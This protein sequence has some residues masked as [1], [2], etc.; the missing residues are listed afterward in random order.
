MNRSCFI[1]FVALF[2]LPLSAQSQWELGLDLT[3]GFARGELADNIDDGIGGG[4]RFAWKPR[5]TAR[6]SAGIDLRL[7]N[8]DEN[9][10]FDP[11]EDCCRFIDE[12]ETQSNIL[13]GHLF[14]KWERPRGFLRPHFELL[15]GVK[16]FETETR[17]LGGEFEDVIEDF[18]EFDDTAFSYGCGFGVSLALKDGP[19]GGDRGVGI[20]LRFTGRLLYGT[21]ATYVVEDS[22]VFEDPQTISFEIADSETNLFTIDAGITFRF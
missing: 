11:Y 10:L 3:G 15:S 18:T 13:M 2:T 16:H 7:I 17:I 1:G 6:W 4:L 9:S 19:H 20:L 8:Y 12:I 21:E 5:P 22:I 14:L